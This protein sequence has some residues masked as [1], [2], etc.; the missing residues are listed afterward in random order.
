MEKRP[1]PF[2]GGSEREIERV[3]HSFAFVRVTSIMTAARPTTSREDFVAAVIDALQASNNKTTDPPSP[4]TAAR[5]AHA[6]LSFDLPLLPPGGA[7]ALEAAVTADLASGGLNYCATPTLIGNIVAGASAHDTDTA[8]EWDGLGVAYCARLLEAALVVDEESA[9]K[10]LAGLVV[11]DQRQDY[12]PTAPAPVAATITTAADDDS[13]S[14]YDT[15]LHPSCLGVTTP[16]PPPPSTPPPPLD[17]AASCR[18]LASLATAAGAV[19]RRGG[20]TWA[21]AGGNAALAGALRAAA[22]HPRAPDVAPTAHALLFAVRDRC[23][24]S[25]RCAGDLLPATWAALG[26]CES[27]ASLRVAANVTAAVAAAWPP[28]EAHARGALWRAAVAAGL[29]DRLCGELAAGDGLSTDSIAASLAELTR[30]AAA[31]GAPAAAARALLPSG[32]WRAVAVALGGDAPPDGVVD[33]AL[34]GAAASPDLASYLSGAGVAHAATLTPRVGSLPASL[35]AAL[36][37][38]GAPLAACLTP[39]DARCAATT[40]AAMEALAR[41]APGRRVAWGADVDAAVATLETALRAADTGEAA[42]KDG[43]AV[44]ADDAPRDTEAA[45]RKN[46]LRAATAARRAAVGGAKND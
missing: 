33:A 12:A 8:A 17:W 21:A 36:C 9:G 39:T 15:P 10:L 4:C 13:D 31:A 27:S 25:P 23:V 45:W 44:C 35:L 20:A 18:A 7:A 41:G 3:V 24:A 16:A 32:A 30:C 11:E 46:A 37:G 29:L 6:A 2:F 34:A 19:A 40:L 5:A 28:S 38:D 14:D 42:P 43:D 1:P 26:A 22:H